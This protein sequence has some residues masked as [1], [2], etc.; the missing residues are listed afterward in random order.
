MTT[1]TPTTATTATTDAK[2]ANRT[3]C[4]DPQHHSSRVD[5]HATLKQ[6]SST[7]VKGQH[8]TTTT[9]NVPPCTLVLSCHA[10]P[11]PRPLTTA[12]ADDDVPADDP[13]HAEDTNSP[14]VTT[15]DNNTTT[16]SHNALPL[17]VGAHSDDRSQCAAEAILKTSANIQTTPNTGATTGA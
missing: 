11:S 17:P 12:T 10:Q 13:S 2:R 3:S 14:L 7:T 16:T 1:V 6:P 8:F 15:T 9:T 5:P 4:K